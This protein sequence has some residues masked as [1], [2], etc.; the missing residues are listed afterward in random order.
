VAGRNGALASANPLAER[1][2]AGVPATPSAGGAGGLPDL[3]REGRGRGVV[4]RGVRGMGEIY[5]AE[6]LRATDTTLVGLPW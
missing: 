5:G 1:L 2:V 3:P 4:S 6:S